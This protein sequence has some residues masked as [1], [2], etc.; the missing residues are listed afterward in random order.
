MYFLAV[1]YVQMK[2]LQFLI[3]NISRVSKL[4]LFGSFSVCKNATQGSKLDAYD[5]SQKQEAE[6][7]LQR[8]ITEDLSSA[9]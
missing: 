7:R 3:G 8:V 4:L 9:S 2:A 5:S 6:G 1:L